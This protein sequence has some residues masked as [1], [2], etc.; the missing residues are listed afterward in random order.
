MESLCDLGESHQL[1]IEPSALSHSP[2]LLIRMVEGE[3]R[4][5]YVPLLGSPNSGYYANIAIGV[6]HPQEVYFISNTYCL[7]LEWEAH[8]LHS[9]FKVVLFD[10]S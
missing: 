7:C 4:T 9:T 8:E 3:G 6:K 10:S 1:V 2:N 5:Y